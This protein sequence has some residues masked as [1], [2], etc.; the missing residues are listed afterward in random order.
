MVFTFGLRSLSCSFT[1]SA[2]IWSLNGKTTRTVSSVSLDGDKGHCW[3]QTIELTGRCFMLTK[4]L[5]VELTRGVWGTL[6][7]GKLSSV[8]YIRLRS[9]TNKKIKD[10]LDPA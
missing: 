4:L 6:N 8:G 7:A 9:V 3:S 1:I 10:M 5:M 2:E